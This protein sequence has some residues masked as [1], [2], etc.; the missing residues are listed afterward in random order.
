MEDYR[1]IYFNKYPELEKEYKKS[2]EYVIHHKNGN[3]NDNRIENLKMITRQE[4]AKIHKKLRDEEKKLGKE[5]KISNNYYYKIIKIAEHLKFN[6]KNIK[7]ITIICFLI[8]K[9][10][11]EYL[12][13]SDDDLEG[14]ED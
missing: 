4:H 10:Y 3:H 13:V 12:L 9:Y 5:I 2:N 1:K 6:L 14:F 11:Q 7:P 8:D